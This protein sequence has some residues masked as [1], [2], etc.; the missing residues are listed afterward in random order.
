MFAVRRKKLMAFMGANSV[1]ILIAADIKKRSRDVEYPY[2]PSNNFYY[3]TGFD[4]PYAI[5]VFVTKP[6]K[7]SEFI[8]FCRPRHPEEEVWMGRRS[9]LEGAKQFYQADQAYDIAEA[10]VRLPALIATAK[11]L[12]VELADAFDANQPVGHPHPL[13]KK[14]LKQAQRLLK[15]QAKKPNVAINKFIDLKPFLHESRL[16]KSDDEIKLLQR[17]ATISVNAHREVI[18]ACQPGK[19]E[20]HL[21]AVFAAS[22]LAQG[23]RALAYPS[24]VG[25]G[26]NSCILHYQ[27]NNA[28]L[29]KGDLLLIDAGAEYRYYAADITRTFPVSGSFTPAQRAI[30]ALVLKTQMAIINAI[31]PGS[32]W[33]T[34]NTVG[35]KVLTEG[36]V[37]LGLLNGELDELIKNKCARQF[38]LH[39]FGHW[40][41]MDVHDVGAYTTSKKE[42]RL[43][44]PGMVLT[45]EPG[46][47]IPGPNPDIESRWWNIGVRIEDD[48]LVTSKGRRVLSQGLPKT[49]AAIERLMQPTSRKKS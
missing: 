14:W 38:S 13:V 43:F 6:S 25:S 10:S 19:H 26:A 8:L 46:I 18:Q 42:N 48:V 40:L 9:G 5:A 24:I 39:S 45:V 22:C 23:S 12:Y 33:D 28:K 17:A 27:T 20:Y 37:K 49:I 2:R 36:L 1:S 47:Y 16:I 32:S 15:K 31:K 35:V 21:E 44:E 41:G 11:K 29:K 30:Y 34:L 3:L 7:K 4:E